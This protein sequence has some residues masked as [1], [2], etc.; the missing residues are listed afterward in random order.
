MLTIW[1]FIPYL[2][3][4][5]CTYKVLRDS[6]TSHL[7]TLMLFQSYIYI[8]FR[9]EITSIGLFWKC[10]PIY[11]PG[12][13]E[14]CSQSY[15]WLHFVFKRN[16]TERYGYISSLKRTIRGGMTF[17]F[18]LIS[19]PLTC[20]WKAFSSTCMLVDLRCIAELTEMTGLESSE[21]RFQKASNKS[22]KST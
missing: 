19:R 21:E 8:I 13:R 2:R 4:A 9:G 22:L 1:N 20:M 5:Q 11:I 6:S 18:S 17:L 16:A 10:S 7:P 3:M 14:L 12:D 15:I